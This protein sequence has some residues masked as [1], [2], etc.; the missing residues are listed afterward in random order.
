MKELVGAQR[1]KGARIIDAVADT[2]A[3]VGFGLK[4]EQIQLMQALLQG[5]GAVIGP[6][7]A[8]AEVVDLGNVFAIDNKARA[9]VRDK[10]KQV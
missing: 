2:Q 3:S 10:A 5:D 4:I 8:I 7:I 1:P 6:R 9:V